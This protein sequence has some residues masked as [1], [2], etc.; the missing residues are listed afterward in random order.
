MR[1][2]LVRLVVNALALSVAAYVVPG[3]RITGGMGALLLV[4]LVFGVVNAF[5]KPILLFFSLPFLI[6]TLGLFALVVNGILLLITAGLTDA[7]SVSGLWP[8]I[9]GSIIIS[10]VSAFMGAVLK[11]RS[12]E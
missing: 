1:N 11:D 12:D 9:L 3:I 5:L 8:A 4:A 7:L 10:L 6:V 2:F